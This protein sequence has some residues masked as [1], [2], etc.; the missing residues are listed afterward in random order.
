[1][2]ALST[3]TLRHLAKRENSR[4]SP[5]PLLGVPRR[6]WPLSPFTVTRG[7]PIV[8][9]KTPLP[10][11]PSN[12]SLIESSKS[13]QMPPVLRPGKGLDTEGGKILFEGRKTRSQGWVGVTGDGLR[14]WSRYL[15]GEKLSLVHGKKAIGHPGNGGMHKEPHPFRAGDVEEVGIP[16]VPAANPY[17]A[18]EGRRGRAWPASAQPVPRFPPHDP[19]MERSEEKGET[20]PSSPSLPSAPARCV[21]QVPLH[22]HRP[23][24]R[25]LWGILPLPGRGRMEWGVAPYLG[26]FLVCFWVGSADIDI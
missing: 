17:S 4:R 16:G 26:W 10:P 14:R 25:I 8:P 23:S 12:C 9:E 5:P 2:S 22:A 21:G 24:R 15:R 20:F 3:Q 13:L 7:V 6:G 18:R 11:A 1:M 19:G